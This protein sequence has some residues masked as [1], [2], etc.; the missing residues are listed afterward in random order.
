MTNLFSFIQAFLKVTLLPQH[1]TR[2]VFIKG[3]P[4]VLILEAE[5]YWHFFF[6]LS[7]GR[8]DNAVAALLLT[9]F[10]LHHLIT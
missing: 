4:L 2:W 3:T 8:G 1:L 10:H 7:C 9:F 5:L 6:L